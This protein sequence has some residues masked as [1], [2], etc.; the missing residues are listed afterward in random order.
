VYR[1]GGTFPFG[2]WHNARESTAEYLLPA[3]AKLSPPNMRSPVYDRLAAGYDRAIGPFERRW[4]AQWR[5]EALSALPIGARIIEIGAGT[6]LNFPHYPAGTHG[7]ATEISCRMLEVAQQ[8]QRP[9]GVALV[10][11]GAERLPFADG[12]FDAACATLV[13]CSVDSPSAVFGELRRIVKPGGTI[14]L[15]EHVRPRGI[16]GPVFDAVSWFTVR[17]FEDHFNRR[18]ADDARQA[19]LKVESEASHAWGIVKVMVCRV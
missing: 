9:A 1:K 6:G 19:G 14:A 18:T 15:L 7:V 4:L 11:C 5:A 3:L 12:A 17:L 10:Q 8:K 2:L 13:L 16:L